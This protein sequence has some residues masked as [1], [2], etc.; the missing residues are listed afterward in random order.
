[1]K[2]CDYCRRYEDEVNIRDI[3]YGI[4]ALYRNI[5]DDCFNHQEK[6]KEED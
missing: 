3:A 2:K 5:C 6:N 1:M 4:N